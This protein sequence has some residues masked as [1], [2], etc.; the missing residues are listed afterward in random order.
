MQNTVV[1]S[2]GRLGN[3]IIRCLAVSLIAKKHD[4]SVDY[5][6]SYL[7]ESLGIKLFKG[8]NK[9]KKTKKLTDDNYFSIL[10]NDTLTQNLDPNGDIFFQTKEITNLLYNHLHSDEVV[11]NIMKRNQ[12]TS[13]YLNNNDLFIHVRLGDS[14]HYNPGLDYYLKAISGIKYDKLYISTDDKQHPII[15]QIARNYPNETHLL[16]YDEVSTIHFASTCKHVILSHG[17]FSAVIG[18]LAFF[19]D[20]YYPEY[21]QGKIWYGDMF[22]IDDWNKISDYRDK[23]SVKYET[24]FGEMNQSYLYI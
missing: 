24:N 9:Y 23:R 17:S 8:K 13:R 12:F 16:M 4:L 10:N 2:I 11:E 3:H 22:S 5:G 6:S 1:G 20:V 7:I 15:S 21:E 14:A 19:S 18:Y